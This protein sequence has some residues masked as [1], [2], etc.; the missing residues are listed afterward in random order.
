VTRNV[1]AQVF[2]TDG[3]QRPALAIVRSLAR[4]GLSVI[5]GADRAVSLA[6]TSK[7]C[8]RHVTYPSPSTDCEA[9]MQF[10]V[11]FVRRERIDV[12]LP[13]TDMTTH[14]V[15][16]SREALRHLTALAVPSL[17]AF[18]LVSDK[19]KLVQRAALCGVPVPRTV[20]L[21]GATDLRAIAARIEYP[22]VVK[23]VR[24][25]IRSGKGWMP[26]SV[27]YADS[28]EDL[29]RLYR[30]VEYLAAC[31]SLI[32]QRIV[33]P[34][35]GVFVLFDRG[36]P[37]AEFAHRRLREKPPA[38][39]VSVLCESVAV[40][41]RLREH[42]VRLLESVGW[43]GIAMVEFKGD[44]ATGDFSLMEVNGRFWG[45][46][47]LAIDAGVDFPA[48]VFDLAHGRRPAA[49][50]VYRAGVKSRWLFGDLDHLLLRLLKSDNDLCLPASG[51]SRWRTLADV[52]TCSGRDVRYEILRADDPRP[53]Q[54]ECAQN[55]R[56]LAASAIARVR[57]IAARAGRS[58]RPSTTVYS[59]VP[60]SG[61]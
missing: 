34:G 2:V 3:E 58:D 15:C 48:L 8:A 37:V 59:K 18:D 13:V 28:K 4:R 30:E 51:P 21:Q 26:T 54:Y 5:V 31:P 43:H 46:L 55:V 40:D 52:L 45:S 23:P 49:P 44:A 32:Q 12:V 11:D 7:Y 53:F 1:A 14:A 29:E 38:G 56:A 42:A 39:G 36:Q 20:Y 17:E 25:R 60:A 33:G 22:A 57:R 10:L 19:W 35:A 47:Q 41:P 6:S 24:S 50:P 9:F 61:S 27:H 16:A